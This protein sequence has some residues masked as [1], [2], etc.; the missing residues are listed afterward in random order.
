MFITKDLK[1]SFTI[2]IDD[3][4]NET[5]GEPS[6]D[7]DQ[8]PGNWDFTIQDILYGFK[9]QMINPAFVDGHRTDFPEHPFQEIVGNVG[10]GFGNYETGDY[11]KDPHKR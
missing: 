3:H 1:L 7:V 4:E 9:F 8:V 2:P 6:H 11:R 5:E 10:D